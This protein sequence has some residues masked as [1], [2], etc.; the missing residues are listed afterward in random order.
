M[1]ASRNRGRL[2]HVL[3]H[4]ESYDELAALGVGGTPDGAT[5]FDVIDDLHRCMAR[6]LSDLGQ[7]V[8]SA[9]QQ[10]ALFTV[11]THRR[12]GVRE[13]ATLIGIR[14]AVA[15]WVVKQGDDQDAADPV[16]LFVRGA[17]LFRQDA[18]KGRVQ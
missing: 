3:H 14:H 13:W 18:F 8:L 4:H 1:A 5:G 11:A 15:E 2:D 9:E 10:D 7:H 17:E 12:A 6:G 16:N